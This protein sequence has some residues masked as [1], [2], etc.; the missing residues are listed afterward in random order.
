MKLAWTALGCLVGVA[1]LLGLGCH[2]SRTVVVH[3]RDERPVVVERHE[4]AVVERPVVVEERPRT[5]VIVR[6]A[7]PPPIVEV[8]EAAPGPDFVW[9][10]GYYCWQEHDHRYVWT[11]GHYAKAPH[12][13]AHWEADR[14]E[15]TGKG[16]E[17]RPGHWR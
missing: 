12:R 8:R 9:I 11:R 10:G 5:V 16:Y 13:G 14:W 15:H 3:D 17:Y 7:P 1:P 6:E 4:E 2:E